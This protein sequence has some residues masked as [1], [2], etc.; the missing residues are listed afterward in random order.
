[1]FGNYEPR[2]GTKEKYYFSAA[3]L[4]GAYSLY[5]VI[6]KEPLLFWGMLGGLMPNLE[7]A[8]RLTNKRIFPTYNGII[9]Y[10]ERSG[11][12]EGVAGNAI[13]DSIAFYLRHQ[14]DKFTERYFRGSAF[15]FI[16]SASY[17]GINGTEQ[18]G[19]D[20][21]GESSYGTLMPAMTLSKLHSRQF[22]TCASVGS[23]IRRA[24]SARDID[25]P[26]RILVIHYLLG[27]ALHP[28]IIH[29]LLPFGS[30]VA[31]I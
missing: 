27:V 16:R 15:A 24:P 1:M 30:F 26:A 23:W 12:W 25:Y 2:I 11:F 22:T 9:P 29:T 18:R 14:D 20:V 17:W 10:S 19:I 13:F 5:P 4:F 6:Q 3:A 31:G 21:V 8:V 28:D 7:H